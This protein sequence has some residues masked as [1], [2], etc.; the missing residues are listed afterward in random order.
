MKLTVFGASGGIGGEVVRQ[1]LD[2]GHTVT[3]VVRD[4]ARFEARHARL[5]VCTVA[6]LS[7]P[8]PLRPAL[9]GSDA[10]LSGIG[11]R[12][13][14]DAGV[15][16]AA[17]RAIL[18]ALADCGVRRFVAVSAA[19]VGA[20]PEGESWPM[21]RV[22]YPLIRAVLRDIYADLAV[23]EEEI[24]DSP[25]DWTVV[26]PPR[27]LDKPLTGGYRTAIGT[28][29]PRAGSISRADVAHAMLAVLDDPATIRQAVGVAR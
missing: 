7:D 14:R 9:E 2:A 21:R 1:A 16:S 20:I 10:A 15:A 26:R 13:R 29:V 12:R 6:G 3:A 19:P 27:L 8:G 11:P 28:N 4:A 18:A 22:A 5:T 23:M 17:T 25:T 24:R